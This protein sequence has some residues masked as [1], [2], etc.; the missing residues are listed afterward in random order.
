MEAI[1][2]M[3]NISINNL[4][5]GSE[6]WV[7]VTHINNPHSFYVRLTACRRIL[8]ILHA[9]QDHLP[10]SE[11]QIGAIVIYKSKLIEGYIRGRV[12]FVDNEHEDEVICD[13]FALD[14]GCYEKAVPSKNLRR[15]VNSADVPPLAMHCQLADCKPRTET[16]CDNAIKSMKFFVGKEQAKMVIRGKSPDSLIV[17]LFNSCPDDIATMLAYDGYTTLGYGDNMI[18]RFG[19]IEPERHY[20]RIKEFDIGDTVTVRLQTGDS[21]RSFYVAQ[22]ETYKHYLNERDNFTYYCKNQKEIEAEKIKEGMAVGV[23]MIS[24][25]KYERAL[26]TTI[27]V[28][29]ERARVMLVDWGKFLEVPFSLM[30]PM[31]ENFF[32]LPATAIHCCAEESQAWDNS[33]HKCLLPGYKFQMTLVK[34]GEQFESPHIVHLSPINT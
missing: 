3:E 33:L 11:L 29:D 5:V 24:L 7:D 19:M 16:F 14:Y 9:Y 23:L 25:N 21:L 4:D 20:Y 18:S 6:H 10:P 28:P 17:E 32:D 22:V 30:K 26:V 31:K 12:M 1:E 27:T 2:K 34:V 13:L 15:I 8:L